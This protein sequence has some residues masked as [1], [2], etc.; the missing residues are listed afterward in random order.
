MMQKELQAIDVHGKSVMRHADWLMW[1]VKKVLEQQ[2]E[3]LIIH[4]FSKGTA[5]SDF[6]RTGRFHTYCDMRLADFPTFDIECVNLGRSLL[7][8]RNEQPK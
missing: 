7:R 8:R 3:V 6:I 5:W 1:R 2:P 4:G